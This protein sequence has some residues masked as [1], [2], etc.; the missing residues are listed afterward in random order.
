VA[1]IAGRREVTSAGGMGLA[2]G[3]VSG[4][5][6]VLRAISE[7]DALIVGGGDLIRND[8][9]W[10]TFCFTMEKQLI[11]ATLSGQACIPCEH[12]G[13]RAIHALW[14]TDSALGS[15]PLPPA[16]LFATRGR[17]EFAGN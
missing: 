10:R 16:S 11:F 7:S 4:A 13:R 3:L 14:A 15:T 5:A 1:W 8:R 12:W 17:N 6:R 9:G 2:Y